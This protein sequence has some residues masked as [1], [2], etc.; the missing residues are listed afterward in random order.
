VIATFGGLQQSCRHPGSA[1][2]AELAQR[3]LFE[4]LGAQLLLSRALGAAEEQ[5]AETGE[6]W[7]CIR[8]EEVYILIYMKRQEKSSGKTR[9]SATALRD[10]QAAFLTLD[11]IVR[12]HPWFVQGS[13]NA[14]DPKSPGGCLTYTWTRKVHAKTVTVALSRQQAAAFCQA[15][16]ANRR[17]EEALSRLRQVSQTALLAELPG[18]T[19]RRL[20]AP[21]N[22]EA[23]SVPKGA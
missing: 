1:D 13:V 4:R 5:T 22:A 12:R 16:K 6:E 20:N 7:G 11:G 14:V 9:Y 18:V 19:K 15:I 21:Q 8:H 23:K 3:G 10:L 2:L 17:I